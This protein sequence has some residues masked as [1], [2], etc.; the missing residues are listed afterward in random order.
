[1]VFFNCVTYKSI[2][3]YQVICHD[4][5]N[6]NPNLKLLRVA[7]LMIFKTVDYLNSI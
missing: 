7:S 1:M 5:N 4:I 6:F 3:T 2:V